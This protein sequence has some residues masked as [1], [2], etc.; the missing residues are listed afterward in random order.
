VARLLSC[1]EDLQLDIDEFDD[2]FDQLPYDDNDMMCVVRT[3]GLFI[4]PSKGLQ[5]LRASTMHLVGGLP[6][7]PLSEC[8]GADVVGQSQRCVG[9][10]G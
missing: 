5:K 6:E 4:T 3:V 9:K 8:T 7:I 2:E 1:V 10:G